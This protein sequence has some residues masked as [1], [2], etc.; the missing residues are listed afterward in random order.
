MH[1]Q[2]GTKGAIVSAKLLELGKNN[3]K[4][5]VLGLPFICKMEVRVFI[6]AL[7]M[8]ITPIALIT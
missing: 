1:A 3:R 8:Q 5:C 6:Q 7:L 2:S 4:V